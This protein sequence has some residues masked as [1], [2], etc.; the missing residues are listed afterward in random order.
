[1]QTAV[2]EADKRALELVKIDEHYQALIQKAI[3]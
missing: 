2:S 3:D 1:M